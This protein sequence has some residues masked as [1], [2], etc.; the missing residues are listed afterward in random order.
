VSAL[1]QSVDPDADNQMWQRQEGE[2]DFGRLEGGPVRPTLKLLQVYS[3]DV[4]T[5]QIFY[6]SD[7][8]IGILPCIVW[9]PRDEVLEAL[10]VPGVV[11]QSRESFKRIRILRLS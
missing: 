8:G 10:I 7:Q 4:A 11:C 1:Q 5:S 9:K 6:M 3:L 2:A